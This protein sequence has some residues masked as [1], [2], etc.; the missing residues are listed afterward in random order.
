[1]VLSYKINLARDGFDMELFAGLD[2]LTG[3]FVEPR[4]GLPGTG[5]SFKLRLKAV[6]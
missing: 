3:T 5:R 1:M 6:F 2:N 4:L